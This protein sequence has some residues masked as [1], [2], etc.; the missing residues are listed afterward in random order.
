MIYHRWCILGSI[1]AL[2]GRRVW[3]NHGHFRIF[4]NIYVM[5][6]GQPAARKSTSIKIAKKLVSKS[7]YKL[8]AADKSSK[9]KFLMDLAGDTDGYGDSKEDGEINLAE[10]NLWGRDDGPREPREVFIVADEFNEFSGQGNLEFYTTLG[11]MWD[12]DDEEL[13]FAARYKNS[14]SLSIFQPYVSILGGNT[15]ENF[16][17]AFPPEIIG[18]GFL[19]RMLIIHGERT[20]VKL[21]FPPTP[22]QSAT[23]TIVNS[24]AAIRNTGRNDAV[25][26][27]REAEQIIDDIYKKW[28]DLDDAR[29]KSYS[30]RRFTQLIKLSLIH[31]LA[32]LS[33]R[34]EAEDVIRANTTLSV[35]ELHMPRGLGEFG[36]ARTSD[37]SHKVMD[38]MLQAKKPMSL[39]EIWPTVSRDLEKIDQLADIVKNLSFAGKISNI[40]SRGLVAVR[41]GGLSKLHVDL[42]VLTPEETE[43]LNI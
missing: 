27:S 6:I 37:V 28:E 33:T 26:R 12:W 15:P 21:T 16:S 34:M 23:D 13:G 17:R 38:V 11:N 18:Q 4:P 9:E 41:G 1:G 30:N 29:F 14:G 32:R 24:L 39:M 8:F 7:G 10:L 22:P 40:K 19:S 25:T 36:K 5:L 42:K 3:F 43:G 20:G 31:T 35:A 2:A